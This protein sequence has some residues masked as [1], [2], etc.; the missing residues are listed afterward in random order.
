MLLDLPHHSAELV[1]SALI[2]LRITV[3]S[4]GVC[5]WVSE[6]EGLLHQFSKPAGADW[7]VNTCKSEAISAC[8]LSCLSLPL[9]WRDGGFL[10]THPSMLEPSGGRTQWGGVNKLNRTNEL[11]DGSASTL[12]LLTCLNAC[13]LLL[14]GPALCVGW[15]SVLEVDPELVDRRGRYRNQPLS[16]QNQ[17]VFISFNCYSS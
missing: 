13:L 16:I 4:P 6:M 7:L 2:H 3:I 15:P 17:C 11:C 10:I 8:R 9:G 1:Q 12:S 5:E 14:A